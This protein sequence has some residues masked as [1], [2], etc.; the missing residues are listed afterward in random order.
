MDWRSEERTRYYGVLFPLIWTEVQYKLA[1]GN[2]AFELAS[3]E[4]S[5]RWRD[6]VTGQDFMKRDLPFKTSEEVILYCQANLPH[7][8]Q[9]GGIYPGY[10]GS[11]EVDRTF[12]H[13][14]ITSPKGP[15]ILDIDIDAYDRSSICHCEREDI[16][17]ECWKVCI[18]TARHV[19]HYL[20]REWMGF[21]RF[22]DVFSG[23]RGV[24]TWCMDPEVLHWSNDARKT[25]LSFISAK[26]M[27]AR[28]DSEAAATHIY[29]R[30]LRPVYAT[31]TK[32]NGT[33]EAVFELLYPKF[34]EA[35]TAD[36]AHLKGFPL[37]IHHITCYI[38]IPLPLPTTEEK[39][40]P[41]FLPSLHKLHPTRISKE[42]IQTFIQ[43]FKWYL[44]PLEEQESRNAGV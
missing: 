40:G 8:L 30:I 31:V 14:K 37:S 7:N 26:S 42:N 5:P 15:L 10:R 27:L 19:I 25:F 36:A 41:R 1:T 16:C 23:R 29:E 11:R 32:M 35:V 4:V 17:D 24:H 22:M 33:P 13:D 3:C 44:W 38:R 28:I 6:R 43:P 20:F 9:L 39:G 12:F 18:E 21:T 34:D 2:G